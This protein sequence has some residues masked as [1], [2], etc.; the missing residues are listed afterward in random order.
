ME[1]IPVDTEK[2][3]II[4]EDHSL[5]VE[6]VPLKHRLPCCGYIFREK[7]TLP[8]IKRDMID[9]YGIP[10][11]QINNI[12]NGADWTNEG[13]VDI[14]STIPKNLTVKYIKLRISSSNFA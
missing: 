4:Y 2:Q 5:S 9:Y 11:S 14:N 3:Q 13:H 10:I 8:H 1:M 6:T 12:K 7:P